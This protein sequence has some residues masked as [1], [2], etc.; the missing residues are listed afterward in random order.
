MAT[1]V[2]LRQRP[3]SN[4]RDTLYLEFY[5]PIVHPL[6]HKNI[7]SESL[8]MYIYQN[9]KTK[10][11]RQ[12]NNDIQ[13]KAEA[14]RCVRF[15]ELL[16]EKYNFTDKTKL[17]MDFLNYFYDK[18]KRKNQKWMMVYSHFERF[19]CKQC[20]YG[21]VTVKLCRDF[22]EYLLNADQI[23]FPSRQ[24]KRN[25]AAG[26]FATF[27]A[28]L[29][30]AQKERVVVENICDKLDCIKWEDVKKE[31]LTLD[32]LH[33]LASVP[34]SFPVLKSASLFACLTGL[35]LGDI[36]SLGWYNIVPRS[37][38]GY[39]I[40]IRTG[41]TQQ[42][43]TLPLSNEAFELCGIPGEGKV[44]KGFERYMVQRPLKRWLSEAGITRNIT[45]H[46]FRHTY[47]TLQL[48]LGTDIYTVSKMLTHRNVTTTQIYAQII[49][50]KKIEAANRIS[51]LRKDSF[52]K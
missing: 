14:L 51:L 45:F 10:E 17:T 47:A 9:P 30:E 13:A 32:E 33:Q 48:S 37:D 5:P 23:K 8:G 36:L 20:S 52:P 1:K 7:R 25:S 19:T 26:Y 27:C 31:Y 2:S 39:S 46:C 3:I 24:I 49:D 18:A 15:Q 50:E 29:R 41:K 35:R 43:V 34:C 42:E 21:D 12:Y 44:F 6:T 38:G 22:R 16:N 40:R 4:G 11:Q 28:L